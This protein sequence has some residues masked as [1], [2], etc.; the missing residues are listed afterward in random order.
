MK[1]RIA[2]ITNSGNYQT[3]AFILQPTVE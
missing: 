1:L 2:E 3:I